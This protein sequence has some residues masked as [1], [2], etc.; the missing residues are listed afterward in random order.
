M[1]SAQACA[2]LRYDLE[3]GVVEFQPEPRAFLIID[4]Q[5]RVYGFKLAKK[6]VSTPVIIY[7]KL[8]RAQECHLF[9]DINTKQKPVPNELLL[10]IRRLSEVETKT[11]AL[12]HSVFDLLTL[13]KIAPWLACS[14][15]QRS[16][17]GCCRV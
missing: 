9:M 15:P 17:K 8:S 5:H 7:D 14:V 2:S 6:S 3:K 11:D 16:V 1:L 4:G 10:D 13:E 12:F